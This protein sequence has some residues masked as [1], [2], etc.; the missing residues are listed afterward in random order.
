MLLKPSSSLSLSIFTVFL[1]A[2]DYFAG[3]PFQQHDS[4]DASQANSWPAV[5]FGNPFPTPAI[6]PFFSI[7]SQPVAETCT[8]EPPQY[9]DPP[10]C[11]DPA[12][13]SLPVPS[14]V[15]IR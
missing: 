15:S 9:V 2:M 4:L 11:I 12:L 7:Y 5:S 8:A 14:T 1:L 3:D 10:L 13:I 6:D